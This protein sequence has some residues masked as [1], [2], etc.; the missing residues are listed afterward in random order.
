V[1][2][3]G[4]HRITVHFV[5]LSYLMSER[6]RYR[7]RLDG[8]DGGWIDRGQQR[9]VEFNGLPPGDYTLHVSAAHP[10]GRWSDSEAVWRFTVKPFLWQRL[11]V[12]IGVGLLLLA[13]L[14]ML[15]RYLIE[16]YRTSNIR[17]AQLVDERTADLQLQAERLLSA[18]EE[19]TDLL[20]RLRQQS[21]AFERQARED[22]LTGLP[23]RRAFDE[24]L[25]RDFARSQ[26]SGHPLC[27]VVL[28]IDHFKQV[29]DLHSHSVGDVVL[30]EVARLLAASCRDSDMPARLGGEEFALLLNDTGVDEAEQVLQRMRGLF[31]AQRNWAGI[32]GLRVTFSAGLVELHPADRTPLLL[33]QRAD[34][35]L[36]KAKHE[37]RDRVVIG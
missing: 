22:V 24:V 9:S 10:G 34:R 15:Y 1:R 23:N 20:E 30:A 2:V 25:T 3:E 17:L 12:Q 36:Y 14:V 7:T 26:R 8:M 4:G 5:G 28:D 32:D 37:G 18:N 27:L 13:G 35:A 16:R 19:K 33:M 11:S 21:E 6:I 29:N 31:H